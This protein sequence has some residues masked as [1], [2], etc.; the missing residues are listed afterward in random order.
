MTKLNLNDIKEFLKTK[1]IIW[2]GLIYDPFKDAKCLKKIDFFDNERIVR[3][4]VNKEGNENEYIQRVIIS[5]NKFLVE[6]E[7]LNKLDNFVSYSEE[8]KKF[9]KLKYLSKNT[10][11]KHMVKDIY[12]LEP[13]T[14][15]NFEQYFEKYMV[16]EQDKIDYFYTLMNKIKDFV[17]IKDNKY[18]EIGKP[19]NFTIVRNENRLSRQEK[20]NEQSELSN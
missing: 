19:Y 9:R 11:I 17:S 12:T 6:N 5:S 18:E 16:N 1:G 14:N 8:W 2:Q 20:S 10:K 13:N 7:K 15:I 4:Y 3:L